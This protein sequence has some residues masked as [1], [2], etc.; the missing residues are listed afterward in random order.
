[1]DRKKRLFNRLLL[2]IGCSAVLTFALFIFFSK[3]AAQHYF[4][5]EG[6][7]GW[8]TVRFEKP[9]MP[10]LPKNDG[11]T[12]YHIPA[13]GILETSS[14][15]ASGWSR[16]AFFR[17][18]PSGIQSIPKQV[19][20]E[21]KSCRWVHDI[22]ESNMSYDKIILDL[23]DQSDTLLWDGARI[24]KADDQAEVRSGRKTM[25]HFWVSGK[26]EAFFYAHDSL[27]DAL[28]AW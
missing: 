3:R 9:G 4:I 16:D 28:K 14:K 1:M 26:P 21:G 2:V 7:S 27:P 25:V 11:A 13:T 19:D 8:V 23:P 18:G 5:P 6:F 15:L 24:S 10:E 20:F 12:E 22:T 17:E